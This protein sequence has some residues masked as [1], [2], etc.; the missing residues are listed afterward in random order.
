MKQRQVI[1]LKKNDLVR[2]VNKISG[3]QRDFKVHSVEMNY[4]DYPDL[5]VRVTYATPEPNDKKATSVV[6]YTE[7]ENVQVR[8]MSQ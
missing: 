1:H 2:M 6:G 3:K 8:E 4:N 7:R 5:P